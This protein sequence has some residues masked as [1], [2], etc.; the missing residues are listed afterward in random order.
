MNTSDK[1]LIGICVLSLSIGLVQQGCSRKKIAHL[2][3]EIASEQPI[4][5]NTSNS[6]STVKTTPTKWISGDLTPYVEYTHV[7]NEDPPADSSLSLNQQ[8]LAAI[9]EKNETL[10]SQELTPMPDDFNYFAAREGYKDMLF[11]SSFNG[12]SNT[13][14][15]AEKWKIIESGDL[16]W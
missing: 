4:S 7:V 12:G 15:E 10:H 1:T 3:N 9:R 16:P 11:S 13:L 2:S 14:S 8:R 5:A 6:S